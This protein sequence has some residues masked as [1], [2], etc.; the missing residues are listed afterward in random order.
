MFS[1]AINS[2]MNRWVNIFGCLCAALLVATGYGRAETIL[3]SDNFETN[4]ASRWTNNG[5]WHIGSPTAGPAVNTNGFRTHSGTNCA[6]TQNYPYSQDA[7]LVCTNY[8]GTN[9]LAIPATNLSPRLRFWH[10]FDYANALGYVELK[11]GTNNW[12]QISP[13]YE[14]ITGGGVWSRPSIDL[15]SFAGHSVQIA[16]HFTSGCCTGNGLGWYVDDV[17]V[18]T[19]APVYNNPESFEAGPNTNN[20]VVDFGTWEIGKPTSGPNAAHS[21]TNC[22]ATILTGNYAN[23]VDSRL[24]SPPFAVPASNSPSLRFWHWCNFNNALGYVEIKGSAGTWSNLSP[25]YLNENTGGVWT[26]VSLDLSAYV[27]QTVRAAFHFTS[28]GVYSAAGWYV[29]DVA[30]VANPVLTVPATQT[31]YAGQSL[32]VTNYVT[33]LP[34]N[35]TPMFSL[36]SPPTAFTN[37]NL[38]S[39]NG[40][41]TWTNTASAAPSTNNI[42]VTVSDNNSPPLGATN[43]FTVIIKLPNPPQ[44]TS[45]TS[46]ANGFQF[47]LNT[48]S[49]TTWRIDASTNLSTWLPIFTNLAGTGGTLQFTDLL[50]TNFPHRFYRAVFP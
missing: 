6:S 31:I 24:I 36:V 45:S 20:W 42:T 39:T 1:A 5:V 50:A 34:T 2:K 11:D 25:I 15:S 12:Q 49:N 16:F 21:G 7:R 27:G 37:L 38:N 30:I 17:A 26:N 41:L 48:I 3:W 19:N 13:T 22:A 8:N 44:L 23:N 32:N 14:N 4:A 43:S 35:D 40:V 47:T 29:D 9:W 18:V 33:L 28:G 10:W 46:A